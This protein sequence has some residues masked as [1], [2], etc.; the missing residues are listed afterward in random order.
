MPSG[1]APGSR[2]HHRMLITG[3]PASQRPGLCHFLQVL[4]APLARVTPAGLEREL[5][6]VCF[7]SCVFFSEGSPPP[8]TSHGFPL[9]AQRLLFQFVFKM[10][11]FFGIF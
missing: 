1:P 9:T 5:Q 4:T 10:N 3:F 8:T 6:G 2:P 11:W 7:L